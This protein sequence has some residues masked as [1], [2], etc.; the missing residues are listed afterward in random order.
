M[1]FCTKILFFFGIGILRCMNRPSES[2][3]R[4]IVHFKLFTR[5]ETGAG[6]PFASRTMT[7][8]SNERRNAV[9]DSYMM[10]T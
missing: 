7:E 2:V 9:I 8:T 6:M 1:F 10:D 3:I 5:L 4:I